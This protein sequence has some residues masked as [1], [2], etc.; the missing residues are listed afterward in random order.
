VTEET[1]LP[2]DLSDA[3]VVSKLLIWRQCQQPHCQVGLY[4]QAP[5]RKQLS[6]LLCKY[7]RHE[8]RVNMTTD[9]KMFRVVFW[10]ILPCKMIVDRRFRGVYCLHH[11]G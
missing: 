7:G 10:D 3:K 2:R 8:S 5:S 6:L 1:S 4:G 11:Q 9:G